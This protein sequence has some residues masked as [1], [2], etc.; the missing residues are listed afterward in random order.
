MYICDAKNELY[1]RPELQNFVIKF[2]L[3]QGNHMQENDKFN[4]FKV[5]ENDIII[6]FV[7]KSNNSW[8]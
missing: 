3:F 5:K 7:E 1:K 8:Y 6:V 2:L 4:K